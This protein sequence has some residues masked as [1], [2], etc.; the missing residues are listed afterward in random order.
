MVLHANSHLVLH[1]LLFA[2][3]IY[4]HFKKSGP[5]GGARAVDT[6][7]WVPSIV[8]YS[9]GGQMRSSYAGHPDFSKSG[10]PPISTPVLSNIL[11]PLGLSQ[12]DLP[13]ATQ[14]ACKTRCVLTAP[15]PHNIRAGPPS[16][17]PKKKTSLRENWHTSPKP[18]FGHRVLI[19]QK[20]SSGA[21][22]LF[23]Q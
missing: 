1:P 7:L 22:P 3:T 20:I 8:L 9:H 16:P 23:F 5:R 19:G 11:L 10:M 21:G 4:T 18:P 17:P 2:F 6:C 15:S 13:F 12:P 14:G